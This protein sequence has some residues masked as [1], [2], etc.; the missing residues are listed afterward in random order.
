MTGGSGLWRPVDNAPLEMRVTPTHSAV[1]RDLTPVHSIPNPPKRGGVPDHRGIKGGGGG[2]GRRGGVGVSL[3]GSRWN[4][5]SRATASRL[6][7]GV[8]DASEALRRQ[9]KL[10]TASA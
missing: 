8:A 6:L 2:G 4:C 7:A 1:L 5:P 10:C 9:T 3:E